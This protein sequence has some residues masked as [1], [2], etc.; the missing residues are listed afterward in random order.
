[1]AYMPR[2]SSANFS[3]RRSNKTRGISSKLS[4]VNETHRKLNNALGQEQIFLKQFD[5]VYS[6]DAFVNRSFMLLSIRDAI[7]PETPVKFTHNQD[8]K[9]MCLSWVTQDIRITVSG[10]EVGFNFG[11]FRIN[12]NFSYRDGIRDATV[13]IEPHKNNRFIGDYMHPHIERHGRACLGN[14]SRM[15]IEHMAN[16]DVAQTIYTITEYLRHYNA[17]DPYRRLLYWTDNLSDNPNSPILDPDSNLS[18]YLTESE[19][20]PVNPCGLTPSMCMVSHTMGADGEC[21]PRG[22]NIDQIKYLNQ[23]TTNL[24]GVITNGQSNQ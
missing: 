24:L 19:G 15:V 1:M 4:T 16:Q 2:R 5:E 3:P 20:E 7:C 21:H 14:V 10:Q 8:S 17:A 11:S 6:D 22:M 13:R 12:V 23:N 18:P 9:S